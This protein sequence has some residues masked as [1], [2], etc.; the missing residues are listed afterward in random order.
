MSISS[1]ASGGYPAGS[2]V[3]IGSQQTPAGPTNYSGNFIP[4]IWS[5]K[6]LEKVLR[7]YGSRSHLEHRL[8]G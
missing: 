3:A 7:C 5:G 8:R 2:G 1:G 4:E 6:L